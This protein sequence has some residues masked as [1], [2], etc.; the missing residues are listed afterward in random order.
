METIAIPDNGELCDIAQINKLQYTMN[1]SDTATFTAHS[2]S[3]TKEN[4]VTKHHDNA[5]IVVSGECSHNTTL[6]AYIN[7]LTLWKCGINHSRLRKLYNIG[8]ID[9]FLHTLDSRSGLLI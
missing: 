1:A 9:I 3:L 5:H 2:N 7:S 8:E 6:T 4:H